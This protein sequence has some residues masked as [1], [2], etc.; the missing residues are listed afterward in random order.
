MM[1][2]P[3]LRPPTRPLLRA[4][5][6]AL[7]VTLAALAPGR[8]AAELALQESPA[9]AASVADGS[10]PAVA[11]RLPEEPLVVDLAAKGREFGVQGG[12]IRTIFTRSRDIRYM[13]VYGYAR[14][15]GWTQDYALAPDI[16]RAVEV[17]EGRRFTFHL[18]KG[19]K[20]S[21]GTPFTTEDLRYWWEDVAN[22]PELAPSGPPELMIVDGKPAKV[23]VIS[24]TEIRYEWDA[25]N[26]RF[27]PALADARPPFIY[28]PAHYMKTY[29]AKYA[30]VDK[31]AEMMRKTKS[32][33]WAQLHNKMDNMYNFDNPELPTLQPWVNRSES[34]GQRYVLTR[35]PFYH[36]VDA[37]GVQ[38]PYADKVET[39]I[40]AAGLVA[41]KV[42]LGE[43]DL[44]VRSLTFSDA[45][46]LKKGEP[47]GG[48]ATY[49][50]SNGAG[51][52]I[53]LYPN[54]NYEE[55]AFRD[56]FRNVEFRRALSLAID[57]KAINKS[58][59]YGLA[60]ERA[61]APLERSPFYTDARAHAW[62]DYDPDKASAMLD[63]LGL[64][65]RD[66]DGTRLL[67]DGQR[68]EIVVETAGERTEESDALELVA[69]SWREVGIKLVFRPLDRDI[70]RNSAYQ[71]AAM[72]PVW[73]GWNNGIPTAETPP[74]D[75][76]PVDQANFSWPMW[77]QYFQT[78]GKAGEPPQLPEAQR[79]LDL[80]KAWS[81]AGDDAG[82]AAAWNE[83]LDIHADQVFAI[84][85]ISSA[86]Q[87]IIVSNRLRNVPKQAIWTWDPGA[88][89][90]VHRMDEFFFQP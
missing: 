19:H 69:E 75:L 63:A 49:L 14:L 41:S 8:S 18:R 42:T 74:D 62:A 4:A 33:N 29:H 5:L 44:Q 78:R 66:G 16:L 85:L 55:P 10:L 3:R 2:T 87:P 79:L 24:E 23:T 76:A 15:V 67:P 25:P 43:S 68:L 50:W 64:D 90:G 22:N 35:N 30:D 86:P 81:E 21:D 20:W 58:L 13:V 12:T 39:E 82:R 52:E 88:H 72:M 36:R 73:Y 11:Q 65:R 89:M 1:T 17:E 60:K 40:A 84:G 77:G 53:A 71:G 48:Y 31:L 59:F 80:H 54:L 70:L 37:H 27:L 32:R 9:L 34:N 46:V 7:A 47:T 45:P 56:L 61:V 83:M 57:R 26:P 6:A 38:L 28:R 51:S